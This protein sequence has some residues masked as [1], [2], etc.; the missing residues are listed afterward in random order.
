[1]KPLS[2]LTHRIQRRE[3]EIKQA[4]SF[5]V[6]FELVTSFEIRRG[7]I[8]NYLP[9]KFYG[10]KFHKEVFYGFFGF[11]KINSNSKKI[12]ANFKKWKIN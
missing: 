9:N 2:F 7:V 8:W 12:L 10:P 4:L 6:Y 11:I 5:C 1:M 3:I